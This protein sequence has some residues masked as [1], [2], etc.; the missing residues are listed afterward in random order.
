[1]L[2]SSLITLYGVSTVGAGARPTGPV[3]ESVATFAI[4]ISTQAWR[5]LYIG[6]GLPPVPAWM[7]NN[8]QAARIFCR[9]VRTAG[10][11]AVYAY[12]YYRVGRRPDQVL[13]FGLRARIVASAGSGGR[14]GRSTAQVHACSSCRS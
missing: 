10:G 3:A 5:Q 6:L 2:Q 7:E 13:A 11:S 1:M 12:A 14:R 4:A 8:P 9:R